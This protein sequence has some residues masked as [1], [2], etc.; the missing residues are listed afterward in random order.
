MVVNYDAAAH[1]KTYI[2]RV[3]RTARAGQQGLA[4]SLLK[5]EKLRWCSRHAQNEL[6]QPAFR[7][8]SLGSL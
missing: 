7:G 1:I 6:L 4:V 5:R 2:H 8:S 3:G